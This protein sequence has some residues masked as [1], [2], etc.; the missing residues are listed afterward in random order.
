MNG[1]S[2]SNFTVNIR[3]SIGY[4]GSCPE[5]LQPMRNSA[6]FRHKSLKY[7]IVD[8]VPFLLVLTL[9]LAPLRGNI[10]CPLS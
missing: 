5:S 8:R 9:K 3:L 1:A 2:L 10:E 7:P 6:V 4:A